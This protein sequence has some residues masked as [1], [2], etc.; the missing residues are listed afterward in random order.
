MRRKWR[1]GSCVHVPC[2]LRLCI[3]DVRW[4]RWGDRDVCAMR[5]RNGVRWQRCSGGRMHVCGGVLLARGRCDMCGYKRGVHRLQCGVLVCW[6]RR[7]AC[8]MFLHRGLLFGRRRRDVLRRVGRVLRGL[9]GWSLVRG[10]RR[11]ARALLMQQRILLASWRC[12]CVC[13][14]CRC[15]RPLRRGVGV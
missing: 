15:V 1:A 4:M 12:N 13:G 7:R 9:Y 6:G 2:G 14:D 5:H 3:G 10:S 8:S 11:S